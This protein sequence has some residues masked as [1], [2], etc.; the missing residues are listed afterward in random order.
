MQPHLWEKLEISCCCGGESYYPEFLLTIAHSSVGSLVE[1]KDLVLCRA[2][3][4][5]IIVIIIIVII[6]IV[7]IRC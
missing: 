6:I 4:V 2:L 7:I 5:I 3:L 1:L